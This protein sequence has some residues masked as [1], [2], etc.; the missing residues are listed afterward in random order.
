MRRSATPHD[1]KTAISNKNLFRL[2][3]IIQQTFVFLK[4]S[5]TEQIAEIEET[6]IKNIEYV[7]PRNKLKLREDAIAHESIS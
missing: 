4:F 5:A 2:R 1:M 6:A 7:K 3:I